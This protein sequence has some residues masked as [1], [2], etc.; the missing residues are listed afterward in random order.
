[1]PRD[2]VLA[3]DTRAWLEQAAKDL[4]RAELL[5]LATPP[6]VEGAWFHSQVATEEALKGFLTWR[7]IAFGQVRGLG[8][9][10]R[11]CA[12]QDRT[13]GDLLR[14]TNSL[15]KYAVQFAILAHRTR[16]LLKEIK[17]LTPSHRKCSKRSCFA[18]EKK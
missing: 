17:P 5:L 18:Y 14:R 4:R 12:P 7:D 13:L 1:M 15:T 11:E 3:G 6:D 9:I 10:G 16:N 8:E 2:E